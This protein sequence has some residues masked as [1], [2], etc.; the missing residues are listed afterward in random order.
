MDVSRRFPL[1]LYSLELLVNNQSQQFDLWSFFPERSILRGTE[2]FDIFS[3]EK[4]ITL[5]ID[6]IILEGLKTLNNIVMP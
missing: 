6:E 5:E 1:E 2:L 4:K 3:I